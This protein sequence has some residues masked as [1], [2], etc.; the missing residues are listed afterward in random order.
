MME[1]L[2]VGS[3]AA[4]SIVQ[5]CYVVSVQ[6][7]LYD[8]LLVRIRQDILNRVYSKTVKGVVFDMSAVTVMDTYVFNHLVDTGKMTL[9]L[10]VETIFIGFQPGVVSA[11]LDIDVDATHVRSYRTIEEAVGHLTAGSSHREDFEGDGENE[12]APEQDDLERDGDE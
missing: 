11:L 9:L 4:V 7:D 1:N 6:A 12:P 8:D 5:G 2:P 10:G 3:K